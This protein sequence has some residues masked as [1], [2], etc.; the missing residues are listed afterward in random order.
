MFQNYLKSTVRT[1]VRNKVYAFVNIF[2]LS[3]GLAGFLLILH[4]IFFET[5][6]DSYHHQKNNIYRV[7]TYRYQQGKLLESLAVTYSP[8]APLLKEELPGVRESARLYKT[9]G[10]VLHE[11]TP[12]NL[13][14]FTEDEVY[15]ADASLLSIFTVTRPDGNVIEPGRLAQANKAIICRSIAEKYFGSNAVGNTLAFYS[16]DYG[17]VFYE[18]T[19]VFEDVPQNSHINFEILLSYPTLMNLELTSM[20]P[21]EQ[22]WG[23]PG[24]YTYL[25]LDPGI[26]P[27]TVASR[28]SFASQK[29]IGENLK[30]NN[31][32][33]DY[34]LQP[35]TSIHLRSNLLNEAGV[36]NNIYVVTFLV[37]IAV[38][39]LLI[40][41]T[42]YINLSVAQ[43]GKRS[44][45][46]GVRK[47]MGAEKSGIARQFLMES[48]V[49]NIVA[50]TLTLIITYVSLPFFSE[51]TGKPLQNVFSHDIRLWLLI[52]L[53][54]LVGTFL[55][56]LTPALVMSSY[57]PTAI[58]RG[59][60]ATTG[61]RKLSLGKVLVLIQF[62]ISICLIGGSLAVYKQLRYMQ[63][64]DLGFTAEQRLIVRGPF[65]FEVGEGVSSSSVLDVFANEL[66]QANAAITGVSYSSA[67]PGHKVANTSSFKRQGQS[68]EESK[69][70]NS[71]GVDYN[72]FAA[73]GI[74]IVAGRSYDRDFAVDESSST[75]ILNE[76]AADLL[77]FASAQDAIGKKIDFAIDSPRTVI[78]VIKD[79]NQESLQHEKS[80]FIYL[81]DHK[82]PTYFTIV[83]NSGENGLRGISSTIANIGKTYQRVFP[84]NSYEYFFL[85]DYFNRQY[86][87]ETKFSKVFFL[88]AGMAVFV[89][90]LGLLALSIFTVT[91]RIKE[92]AIRKIFGASA[93]SVFFMLA[94]NLL[95]VV[96]LANIIALPV[97][98][99]VLNNWLQ[100]FSYRIS[101]SI[102][103]F[104]V[105]GIMVLLMAMITIGINVIKAAKADQIRNL[106]YE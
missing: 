86:I 3:I 52:P 98:Y 82:K 22:N 31:E 37:I 64:H 100:N 67:I 80:P 76:S 12:G 50:M 53:V 81:I 101:F 17:K 60:V 13:S 39:T 27:Q 24:F 51:L 97:L 6:Y 99:V 89:A 5:S 92:I 28:I 10:T 66:K 38:L 14:V 46:V 83:V 59:K 33:E 49:M 62:A 88:F 63:D 9:N 70:I 48:L 21:L 32:R 42:N 65:V 8:M 71:I 30:R 74:E 7:A 85:E 57:N 102:D 44:K 34:H 58:L 1:L 103:L 45:E 16:K 105:P 55:S 47:V 87:S 20:I 77:G 25:L 61:F 43:A 15:F 35:I 11:R 104:V 18:V 106:R 96:V 79:Y 4:Y 40:A 54:V 73:Y 93:T 69:L 2:G 23:W 19:E 29:F 84:E 78:G 68:R 91:N 75:M 36:N 41:Y 26:D 72:F 94:S 90:C 95:S 56:G